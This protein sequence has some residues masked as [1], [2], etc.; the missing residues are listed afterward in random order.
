MAAILEEN[1]QRTAPQENRGFSPLRTFRI[2]GCG[3]EGYDIANHHMW[4]INN[5][6]NLVL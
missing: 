2:E 3:L 1:V 4:K 6:V 5:W